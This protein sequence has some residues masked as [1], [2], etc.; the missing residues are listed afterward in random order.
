MRLYR[1]SNN[2]DT[3]KDRLLKKIKIDPITKCWLFT[4]AKDSS[5]YGSIDVNDNMIGAHRV[6][7]HFFL[8]M[9]LDS[10]DH[11]LHKDEICLNRHCINPEH[12]YRGDQADNYNDAVKKGTHNQ[13]RKTCCPKCGGRYSLKWVDSHTKQE[14]FCKRCVRVS[15]LLR[16]NKKK[17]A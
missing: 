2:Y 6:S 17:N 10:T 5:G 4:G 8:Y 1:E 13:A 3:L 12:I 15:F 14:R 16:K 11:V 9:P 7:A